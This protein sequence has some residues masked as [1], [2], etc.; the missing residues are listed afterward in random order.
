MRSH[1]L[2]FTNARGIRLAANLDLPPDGAPRAGAL[3]GHC[4]TCNRNYRYIRLLSRVLAEQGIAVLRLDFTGLGDSEG[5]FEDSNFTTSVEDVLAASACM[6]R[7]LGHGPQL[8]IGHSLGGTAMLAAAADIDGARAVVTINSP[9]EPVHV[10]TQLAE[11]VDG[12][13]RTGEAEAVIGGQRYRMTLQLVE[14]LRATRMGAAIRAI[15][16]ALL[17]LHAPGDQT[18]GIEHAA[19]IFEAA[20]HPKSFIALAGADHLLSREDDV[21][22]VGALIGAWSTPYLRDSG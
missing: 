6:V 13:E 15:D 19:R 1:R 21:R 5:L 4:F 18:V 14:D 17:V 9:F 20:R 8:L 11:A 16:A 12:V 3:L 2:E 10:L 7:E 22:Y